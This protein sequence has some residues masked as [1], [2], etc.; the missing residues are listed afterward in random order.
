VVGIVEISGALGGL[1]AAMDIAKGLNAAADAVAINDAKIALQTAILEAQSGLL[2][3]QEAQTSNLRRI[4]QL[5]QEVVSLKDWSRER[6]RYHLVDA[7]RGALA[8]M[9]KPGMENGE[10]AHWLCANC[11][12]QGRKSFLLFKG[13]DT[14][15]SGGRGNES[16]YGCDGCRSSFKVF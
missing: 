3:A 5:E 2:A 10:P 6:E 11:F 16:T 8:Y 13:Q 4:E 9:P 1:K 15:K 7:D 14:S 12:N